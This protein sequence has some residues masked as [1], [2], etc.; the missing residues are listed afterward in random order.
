MQAQSPFSCST[1]YHGLALRGVV[2][3]C[4]PADLSVELTSP[5]SGITRGA[6][7]PA[8]AMVLRNRN[9]DETGAVTSKGEAAIEQCLIAA[10]TVA[11][12]LYESREALLARVLEAEA[13][14]GAVREAR[15]ASEGK[16]LAEKAANKRLL[17]R[18]SLS[19]REYAACLKS[20]RDLLE[21]LQYRAHEIRRGVFA[22]L[23]GARV[24]C[25]GEEQAMDFVK[26][27]HD[28]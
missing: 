10:Y 5:F 23:A 8:F 20:G 3:H 13:A 27:C 7:T 2:V 11:L 1:N 14:L 22:G 16:F 9:V 28:A 6:H 18:G 15:E 24:A 12:A 17:K 21:A 26:K 4:G 19:E 25:G